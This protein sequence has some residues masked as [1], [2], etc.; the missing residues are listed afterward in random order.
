MQDDTATAVS[1]R[2]AAK[3]AIRQGCKDELLLQQATEAERKARG[4]AVAANRPMISPGDNAA[5]TL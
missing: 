3:E 2:L 1:L 4:G 5:T